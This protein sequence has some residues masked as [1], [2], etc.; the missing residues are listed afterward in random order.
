[1]RAGRVG[2]ARRMNGGAFEGITH[3]IGE[4]GQGVGDFG[5]AGQRL[6]ELVEVGT[7]VAEPVDRLDR[8]PAGC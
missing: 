5:R 8:R 2:Q 1:M 6:G 3:L 4:G 7:V